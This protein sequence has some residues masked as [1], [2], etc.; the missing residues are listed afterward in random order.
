MR[1]FGTDFHY[2][3]E[4][5]FN[6]KSENLFEGMQYYANGR[7]AIQ[8][9]IEFKK[10]K[11]I[12]MPEYF[13]YDI[14]NSLQGIEIS[15]YPDAPG[16]N[17]DE[18]IKQLSFKPGDVLFRMNFF[19][20]RAFRDSS[21]IEIDVIEDHSHDLLGVWARNSNADFCIAS[22]RKMLPIPEGGVLWSPQN[23]QLPN[24][25]DQSDE[26][27]RLVSSRW[28][29]MQMK[30]LYIDF[31]INSK[32][33]FRELYIATEKDFENLPISDLT[34]ECKS[35]LETFDIEKWFNLKK[36]NWIILSSNETNNIKVVKP[37]S[38]DCNM[39]AFVFLLNSEIEREF[40]R[41]QLISKSIYPIVLWNLPIDK[42]DFALDFSKRMIAFHCDARYTIE[43]VK[44]IFQT[45]QKILLLL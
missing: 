6:S 29:A 45:L 40:V 36:E 41:E 5:L 25:P 19:G 39:F 26:N 12:W 13:C 31:Q 14:I 22:I 35:Y 7:Q 37:E 9:L 27:L 20:M 3:P 10:W 33:K 42:N 34:N 11:R 32:D 24:R 21:T 44:K 2:I 8:H 38:E 17:D 15:F 30:S 1:E 28:K 23:L 18:I 43:D 4:K 16:L